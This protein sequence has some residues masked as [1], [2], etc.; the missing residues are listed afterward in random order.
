MSLSNDANDPDLQQM[1]DLPVELQCYILEILLDGNDFAAYYTLL[2]HPEIRELVRCNF[3][4][5]FAAIKRPRFLASEH[6]QTLTTTAL[7]A[8]HETIP[9]RSLELAEFLRHNL[10]DENPRVCV[11]SSTQAIALL[12]KFQE[13]LCDADIL[14][15]DFAM[16]TR[17]D[18]KSRNPYVP[19]PR[20]GTITLS[21]VEH[22]RIL[23]AFLRLQLYTEIR[24]LYGAIESFKRKLRSLFSLWTTWEFD[25]LRSL[26]EWMKIARPCVPREHP[27]SIHTLFGSVNEHFHNDMAPYV[28]TRPPPARDHNRRSKFAKKSKKWADTPTTPHEGSANARNKDWRLLGEQNRCYAEYTQR[29]YQEHF[30]AG[31]Y[32]FW[33]R[34][35]QPRQGWWMRRDSFSD[36]QLQFGMVFDPASTRC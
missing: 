30:L 15:N 16:V 28:K 3:T 19:L 12:K 18:A 36:L 14:T 1:L 13:C 7:L 21:P 9:R 31:G 22:H 8:S 29:V 10:R 17:C 5:Q 6:Q 27:K 2:E 26:A 11:V 25:E 20:Y 32:P 33:S 4:A 23:R 24:N 35:T 34:Y